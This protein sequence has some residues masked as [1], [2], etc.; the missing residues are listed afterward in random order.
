MREF[1]ASLDKKTK[2]L[3]LLGFGMFFLILI[4]FYPQ[5]EKN[6]ERGL[7]M[8]YLLLAIFVLS[9]VL[10]YLFRPLKY[11]VTSDELI[12]KRLIKPYV[13]KLSEI[14]KIREISEE[15]LKGTKRIFGSGGVFGYFGK[16]RNKNFG[17]M[18]FLTTR[19]DNRVYILTAEGKNIVLSPDDSEEFVKTIAS[20]INGE[21]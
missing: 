6:S 12:V 14:K 2:R 17:T 13:I 10:P 21:G 11:T 3:T 8:L 19:T 5:I 9:Y 20:R 7:T 16:F 15:E 18:T 4:S 1:N